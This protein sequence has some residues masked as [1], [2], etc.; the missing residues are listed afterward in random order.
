MLTVRTMETSEREEVAAL[1]V[2]D[3]H[4]P[5]MDPVCVHHDIRFRGLTEDLCQADR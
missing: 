4:L 1:I 2:H 5:G 3:R